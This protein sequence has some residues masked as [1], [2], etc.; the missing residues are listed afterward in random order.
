MARFES[1]QRRHAARANSRSI[2]T[3]LITAAALGACSSGSGDDG[4]QPEP[5]A[6]TP[7]N[8]TQPGI[9][10]EVELGQVFYGV[11]D[12]ATHTVNVTNAIAGEN[13]FTSTRNAPET[14]VAGFNVTADLGGYLRTLELVTGPWEA[15]TRAQGDVMKLLNAFYKA[16]YDSTRGQ[17]FNRNAPLINTVRTPGGVAD[18][19]GDYC[20]DLAS[21]ATKFGT[22]TVR[23]TNGGNVAI[24][25]QRSAAGQPGAAGNFYV[26]MSQGQKALIPQATYGVKLSAFNSG[27]IARDFAGRSGDACGLTTANR[28]ALA[29]S[30]AAGLAPAFCRPYAMY[31]NPLQCGIAPAPAQPDYPCFPSCLM[32]QLSYGMA[33]NR[34]WHDGQARIASDVVCD[35]NDLVCKR[36][37]SSYQVS[38]DLYPTHFGDLAHWS[39]EEKDALS[40]L[41][42]YGRSAT[43]INSLSD[44]NVPRGNWIT[45]Q[46]T[47]IFC[48][49]GFWKKQQMGALPKV[50]FSSFRPHLGGPNPFISGGNNQPGAYDPS[51]TTMAA[52]TDLICGQNNIMLNPQTR[53]N[54]TAYTQNEGHSGVIGGDAIPLFHLD[55]ALALAVESRFQTLLVA[56]GFEGRVAGK[57]AVTYDATLMKESINFVRT[58]N[59]YAAER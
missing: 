30:M 56:G 18:V 16:I 48:Y 19:S 39:Q 54:C 25:L 50:R 29:Q 35:E 20:A 21:V 2:L 13:L 44:A 41:L 42:I 7:T 31:S 32:G 15:T 8:M 45:P 36:A 12:D 28:T 59:G 40:G 4:G 26:C 37:V 6:P 34:I 57:G 46:G 38:A 1:G 49:Q 11:Y 47:R 24:T 55:G 51:M 52:Y 43:W 23:T 3:I 9:G 14:T 53:A 33:T 58:I 22:K 17:F 27:A 5:A 10:L